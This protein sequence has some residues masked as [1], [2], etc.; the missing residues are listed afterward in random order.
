MP[1]GVGDST[2][3]EAF[4]ATE[5]GHGIRSE[6]AGLGDSISGFRTFRRVRREA[7]QQL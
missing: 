3:G 2:N 7:V 5:V 4:D 1:F 6:A